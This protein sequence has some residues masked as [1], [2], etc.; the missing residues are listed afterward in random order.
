MLYFSARMVDMT[1]RFLMTR[2]FRF[3]LFI[4]PFL[5][6][7]E[8]QATHLRAGEITVERLNCTSLSFRICITVYT[9]T[10]S[11]IRFGDGVLNFGDGSLPHITPTVQNTTRPDLGPNV[12]TVTYCIVHT[13][14]GPGQYPISY[15]E[16][17]RNAGIL[18]M[19]NSVET[20]FYLETIINIDPFL[21]CDNSPRLLVPPIDKACTGA[22]WYHNPGAYDP[23]GDSLSYEFTIPRKDKGQLVNN[24][25]DPNVREFYDQV[26]IDYNAANELKNGAPTFTINPRTGT[27]IWDAPGKAGE[28]NI[29][30]II[31][32]WRKIGSS[33]IQ[34]GS[35]VRDM[36]II[37]DD[38][39]NTRPE[40][41]VPADICVEAGQTIDQDIFGFDPDGDD[42]KIEAF[43]QVFSISPSPA[44]ISPDPP[45]FQA[46][47]P[48]LQAKLKF[49]WNTRCEHIKEQPYQVVFKITDKPKQ[50]ASLVQF[51]TWNIRVVGPAPVWK[52][53][54]P[55]LTTRSANLVWNTYLCQS[56]V[57]MQV[58]RRVDKFDFT[59]P[60]CVTG[61]P[62]FLGFAQIAEV[63]IGQTTYKDNNGGRGLASGAEYCY[64]LV[65][66]FPLP[67]GGESYVSQ[68]ICLPPIL[69]DVPVITNVT[70][71]RTNSINGQIT[72]K[73]LPPFDASPAQFPLPYT[74]DVFRAEGFSG[75]IKLLKVNPSRTSALTFIDNVP[76]V[77]TEETIY[78][79]RI[80]CYD[81]NGVKV[82]TSPTASSVRLETK[83]LFKEIQLTWAFDVP[84]SNQTQ[85]Y[86]RHL[87]YRGPEGA[88][89]SQ[90]QLID[91]V[92]VNERFFTYT[93]SGQFNNIKLKETEKYCYRVMTRGAYG[94]PKIKEPL[95][96]F[97]QIVCA[98][99]NDSVPPCP[100]TI[101]AQAT[102]CETFGQNNSCNPS[103]FSNVI[104]WTRP[105]DV[106]CRADIRSYKIYEFPELGSS[107]STLLAEN[108]RD[109]FYIHTNIPS[110]ARCYKVSAVD[111]SGNESV[112]SEQFCFDN[113]P[114]Y[115]LPNVFTPNGDNCNEL[116]SAYSD[117]TVTDENGNGPCGPIDV[118][119]QQFK[120]ARF[121]QKVHFTVVNRW[122]KEVYEF[123]SGGERNI[124]IDWDGR[125]NNGK[126]LST[127]IYY[128]LAEVT[129]D[130]VDPAQREQTIRGWVHLIR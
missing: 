116:F 114:H 100:P 73:W 16:P 122:G 40:L 75:N 71:D 113:C 106:A 53:A 61:M 125:D 47:S 5:L 82:G 91:S 117:R 31:K 93:D 4:V 56:A 115:E 52:T 12:G 59:P 55:D 123:E 48:S 28:Y 74:Y 94:N 112:V 68:D 65:A 103:T 64:R 76:P 69:A 51:K 46:S 89:E 36:Q 126:E 35:V 110:Y 118:L 107:D 14:P 78:N 26:G 101:V 23:D 54:T 85:N 7:V 37:V 10:G 43:S 102:N 88:T 84:W 77:N 9:N 128:Y 79:Y 129:F 49:I 57:A 86:P 38:C 90:L 124:Y 2:I 109:T 98:Q 127:G 99:P 62:D 32:E 83:P 121:V 18:N 13:F 108:V 1:A 39:D 25:R 44:T 81:A 104:S 66:V 42:V 27:I 95:Q 120:C 41:Q 45:T 105:D 60:V 72:V 67:G 70:V 6:A 87:I 97:S 130:V 92:D 22:S 34:L 119:D 29:A 8:S 58:W 11:E 21:G 50:G 30:F 80:D 96:N 33:W 111:R 20:R 19:F 63:P 3:F 24:Y 15:L 17:N